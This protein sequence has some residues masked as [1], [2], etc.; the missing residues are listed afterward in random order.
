MEK[1]ITVFCWTRDCLRRVKLITSCADVAKKMEIPQA[2]GA[3][4]RLKD[5]SDKAHAKRRNFIDR[6]KRKQ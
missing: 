5:A 6:L 4:K 2:S 1:I 3:V